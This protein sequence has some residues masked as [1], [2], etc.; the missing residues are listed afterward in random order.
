MT[1]VCEIEATIGA[2]HGR[3]KLEG[4]LGG[5]ALSPVRFVRE[6]IHVVV[7][8]DAHAWPNLWLDRVHSGAYAMTLSSAVSE[9]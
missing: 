2:P 6:D 9:Q 3:E 4:G 8:Q 7:A 1:I 5:S